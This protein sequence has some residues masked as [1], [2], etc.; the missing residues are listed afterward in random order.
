MGKNELK[1]EF[2]PKEFEQA[3]ETFKKMDDSIDDK[4][5][6]STLR[7]KTKPME[8]DMKMN[9][10]STRVSQTIGRTTSKK[11]TGGGVAVLVGVV[12]NIPSLFKDISS[13][14]LSAIIEYGTDE[15][16]RKTK[17]GSIITGKV[18]TGKVDPKPYLR[19]AY[20]RNINKLIS[21][22]EKTVIKRVEKESEK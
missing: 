10:P 9:S 13:F 19:P 6:K 12:K 7:R 2:D 4:Y 18:S 1:V 14:G 21:E 11:K 5:L 16:F 3:M 20:D 17:V 15:R 8:M 22:V